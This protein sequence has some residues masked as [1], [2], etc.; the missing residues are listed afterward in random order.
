MAAFGGDHEGLG[1][2]K[3]RVHLLGQSQ[4]DRRL[5]AVDLV[6]RQRHAAALGDIAKLFEDAFHTLGH[7]TVRFDQQH[8]HIGIRRPAPSSGDHGAVQTAARLEQA[9]GIDEDQLRIAL[10]RHAADAGAGGLDLMC[11]DRDLGPDHAV[12]QGGFARVGLS[13]QGDESGTGGHVLLSNCRSSVL[14]AACSAARFDGAV[15]AASA[16]LSNRAVMVKT[17]A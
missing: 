7:A 3:G 16:P 5:D 10:H 12:Q 14:A 9:G 6:D 8:D 11:H 1:K 15:A 2:V 17:G 13:D 4:Q